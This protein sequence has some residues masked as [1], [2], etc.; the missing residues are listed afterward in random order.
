MHV[1]SVSRCGGAMM[2]VLP[3]RA[4][5]TL[6]KEEYALRRHIILTGALLFPSS[7][8]T[9]LQFLSIILCIPP[10][11]RIGRDPCGFEGG[12]VRCCSCS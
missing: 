3:L 8:L 12:S 9:S 10:S 11:F 6:D 2:E 4:C 5:Y 7:P 1:G